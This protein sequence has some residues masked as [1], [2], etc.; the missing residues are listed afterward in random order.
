MNRLKE[1]AKYVKGDVVAD[2]GTDH[3][4]LLIDLVQ[5]DKIKKGIAC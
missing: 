1:I 2:I 4:H 3:A 5:Q